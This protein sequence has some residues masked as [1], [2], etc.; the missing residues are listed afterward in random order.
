MPNQRYVPIEERDLTKLPKWAQMEIERLQRNLESA[1]EQLREGDEDSNT[2]TNYY[3]D[4]TRRPL[5]KDEQVTF[6]LDEDQWG[7]H[8]YFQVRLQRNSKGAQELEV[9][10]SASSASLSVVP[11]AS[12]VVKLQVAKWRD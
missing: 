9:H 3:F 12:N 11:Q 6:E 8:D 2:F 10:M 7:R 5:G 1:Q 4:E